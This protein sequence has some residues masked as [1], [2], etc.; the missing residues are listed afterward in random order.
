M[1]KTFLKTAAIILVVLLGATTLNL[2]CTELQ[3]T[4]STGNQQLKETWATVVRKMKSN[5]E[6]WEA[7]RKEDASVS[8]EDIQKC[9]VYAAYSAEI[10]CYHMEHF[11]SSEQNAQLGFILGTYAST[12]DIMQKYGLVKAIDTLVPA[13]SGSSFELH[14][15]WANEAVMEQ[16]DNKEEVMQAIFWYMLNIA[17]TPAEH[18]EET[19]IV[20]DYIMYYMAENALNRL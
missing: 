5:A 10:Y 8:A 11:L 1:K 19:I 7:S 4:I 12:T 16:Q 14:N 15:E 2:F 13:F 3:P 9:K 18:Y 6:E 17:D 20:C